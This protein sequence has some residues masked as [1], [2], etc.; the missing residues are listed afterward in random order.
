MVT[1]Y[2]RPEPPEQDV[3]NVRTRRLEIPV[4]P[5][6]RELL[7]EVAD[8]VKGMAFQLDFWSRLTDRSERE[9]QIMIE[10]QINRANNEIRLRAEMRGIKWRTGR[11]TNKEMKAM[12]IPIP[13]TVKT[14]PID[15]TQHIGKLRR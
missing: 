5:P 1:N 15:M 12:G 14:G 7:R 4:H 8:I 6:D 13:E 10:D 2:N 9:M 3:Q 11:P